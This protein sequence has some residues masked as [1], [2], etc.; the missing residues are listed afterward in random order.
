MTLQEYIAHLFIF[1]DNN[2]KQNVLTSTSCLTEK[3]KKIIKEDKF[4]SDII[5]IRG[6]SAIL[7]LDYYN[8]M[9]DSV[10]NGKYLLLPK[11]HRIEK[12][13]KIIFINP[14]KPSWIVTNTNGEYI[15]S[16]INGFC[17]K[18][19]IISNF[20]ERNGE[21]FKNKV[22]FFLDYVIESGLLDVS[23]NFPI[24]SSDY[25]LKI[26]QF[27]ISEECNLNCKYCYAT[28]RKELGRKKMSLKDY[29]QVVDDL[30]NTF[31]NIR[32]TLTGGEPLLNK[33]CFDIAKY[34]KSKKCFVNLLT[35][36]TL[37][38]EKNIQK[39]KDYFDEVRISIDG[40]TAQ[41]HEK[42]RGKNSY[43]KTEK[44]INLLNEYDVPY[45]ISMTVN[46]L[47]IEDVPAMAKKYGSRLNYAPLFPAGNAKK[48]QEDI[49]ISGL[50]YYDALSKADGVNP[51][52]YCESSLDGAKFCRLCKCA[53]GDA[54][55]SISPT[56]DVYPCQLL[57]YP[58]FFAG[59]IFNNGIV[60]IYNKS[61]ILKKCKTLTVD[62]IKGCK[63]CFLRYIC[64]GA[65]RA[66]SFHE[67]GDIFSS[68]NF[69]EYEKEAFINGILQIYSKNK[70]ENL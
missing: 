30:S 67:C 33:D 7:N 66:R 20:C 10:Q 65:C 68:G 58:E 11:L 21:Q 40:S 31:P 8:S 35:N 1:I 9:L 23:N 60:D 39:I 42:F 62:N 55:I 57:H 2:N 27:S 69:C 53:I 54:E 70:F 6:H 24:C 46:K 48:N 17:T 15:L 5:S 16:F 64:A 22:S 63:T 29:Q 3:D 52:S 25:K 49:S 56:G 18:E 45:L 44:A 47:N 12:N 41:M 36:A 28:D 19:S 38:D 61:D 59:N 50:D 51:L 13:G 32:Y 14:T 26:V 34:I 4:L 37:I 43:K